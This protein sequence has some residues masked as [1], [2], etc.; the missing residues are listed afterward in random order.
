MKN[1]P[2][3]VVIFDFDGTIADT[4]T[5][6]IR[7]SNRLADEFRFQ[8]IQDDEVAV[9]KTKTIAEIVRHLKIPVAKIPLILYQIRRQMRQH[10][11][12]APAAEG[13]KD[14]LWQMHAQGWRLGILTSNSR[15]N[16]ETFLKHNGLDC[17]DFLKTS[18]GIPGKTLR[19][20]QL[21]RKQ[22]L[23]HHEVIYVGDEI[24]D[25]EAAK[26]NRIKVAAVAW[27]YN[28]PEALAAYQPDYLIRHPKELLTLFPSESKHIS[29]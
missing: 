16:V 4:L 5:L 26:S 7:I 2:K 15:K 20:K 6:L 19:L 8:K 29:G 21:L 22:N 1:S 17:F 27:G 14:I 24:R 9:L 28:H 12:Q 10:I 25:I 3:P 13:L 11:T 23:Q 18:V